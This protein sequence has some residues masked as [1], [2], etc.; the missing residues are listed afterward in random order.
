MAEFTHTVPA[1]ERPRKTE[2]LTSTTEAL[3]QFTIFSK[4]QEKTLVVGTSKGKKAI[5]AE[6]KKL[7]FGKQMSAGPCI[8]NG[9]QRRILTD[10]L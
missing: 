2:E 3:A 7:M 4:R 10:R 8:D 6:T 5:Q 9:I 1:W